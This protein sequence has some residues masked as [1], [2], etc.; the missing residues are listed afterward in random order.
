MNDN[1]IIFFDKP[2]Y[3]TEC[4]KQKHL[5]ELFTSMLV[6]A[7]KAHIQV[8]DYKEFI[9]NPKAYCI[10]KYWEGNSQFFPAGITKEKAIEGT[11]FSHVQLNRMFN[12]YTSISKR[13]K[14]L[15][16]NKKSLATTVNEAEYNHY[17][18][19]EHKAHYEALEKYIES[20]RELSRFEKG[21]EY[22]VV[23]AFKGIIFN[24]YN[25]SFEGII[26]NP[27]QF[28]KDFRQRRDR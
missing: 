2:A 20:A 3:E 28:K 15:K 5:Q 23:D 8:D 16:V 13:C 1:K 22:E 27:Q 26:I 9:D 10:A 11:G 25:R 6:E 19:D 7:E 18:K 17:L 21:D 14:G 4:K 12:E 24:G